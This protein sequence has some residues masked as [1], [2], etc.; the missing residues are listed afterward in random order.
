MVSF[1]LYDIFINFRH[2]HV[3]IEF[4]NPTYHP[5]LIYYFIYYAKK[6]CF[7]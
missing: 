5:P 4:S 7:I 3:E 2:N 6:G 1:Q